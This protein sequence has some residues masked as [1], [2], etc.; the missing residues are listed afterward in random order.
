L[1]L[2]KHNILL[3]PPVFIDVWTSYAHENQQINPT[4]RS[5]TSLLI[6]ALANNFEDKINEKFYLTTAIAYTNGYPHIGHAYEFLSSDVIVRYNRLFGK[7]TYFLTG[8]DEHGQKVAASAEKNGVTPI[9]HCNKYVNAFKALNQRLGVSYNKYIR[10]TDASHEDTCR[11]LWNKCADAGDIYLGSYE[12]WYNEREET[13]VPENEAE[14]N[15]F[16]DPD[17]GLPL[18][19]VKEESYFFRLSNYATRLI[20]YIKAN[21]TFIE[22]A[23]YRDS[24]L[25]RLEV[26]GLKDLSISRTTF[27]WGITLP[28]GYESNHVMYVWF[29]ALTNYLS[30]VNGL[31]DSDP[32]SR[33]WSSAKHVIGKD[34]IWF[35]CVIWPC[36]LMSAGLPLPTG[37][38]AHGFVNGPD[39]RKMSKSLNNVVDPMDILATY[40]VDSVRYYTCSSTTYGSD[41]NFSLTNLISTH[42][43]ELNDILGN[44]VH[45]VLTLAQNYCEGKVPATV[46]DPGFSL[47]FDAAALVTDVINDMK[48][49]SINSALFKAMD[50]ARSTNRWLTEAEPW[51]MKG[52]NIARRP[53]IVRTALEA[54][55]IFTHFLAPV[56]P[57][58][59]ETIFQKIGKS[60][61]PA[62]RL[63][64]DFYNLVPGTTV[65]PGEILF[66]KYETPEEILLKEQEAKQKKAAAAKPVDPNQDNFTKIDLRVAQFKKVWHH[67]KADRLYCAEVDMGDGTSRSVVSGIK[68]VYSIEQLVNRKIVLV[69]NLPESKFVGFLSQGMVLAAKSADGS[70]LELVIPPEGAVVGERV[71]IEGLTGSALSEK[72]IKKDKVWEKTVADLKTNSDCL[73]C[74]QGRP[75]LTSAGVCTVSSLNDAQIS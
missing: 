12:G 20:E 69:C 65:S 28:E 22:P 42:N 72:Q 46:H 31:D 51:K 16:M 27:T 73:V 37:V 23:Q 61:V 68:A 3:V 58:T 43:S 39:G 26:E 19:K 17:S 52:D 38:F 48:T 35:H 44:L 5:L 7:D 21:P 2:H 24:I 1:S 11:K 63:Q 60:P 9:E 34:I 53:A 71:Y 33:Y 62:H 59:A 66:Q 6:G 56:I 67:E 47:P 15:N 41:I 45:R 29:D 64:S 74:W 49:C 36:M 50:A 55:Y 18:K 14:L 70:L 13:F 40:Q 54:I 8:A 4:F 57:F 30:G 75:L 10:T 32:L 25:Q